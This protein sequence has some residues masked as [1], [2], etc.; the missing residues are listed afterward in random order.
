MSTAAAVIL[1]AAV[2]IYAVFG[3]ADFGAGFWD[4]IAGGA[5][6]GERPREV[7]DHSIAPVWE[8]NHVWLIFVFVRAV[9]LLPRGLR[10]D[11][12]H[13]VRPADPGRARHRA[14]RGELRVPQGGDPH[15]RPT[16][17]RRR[18]RPLLGAGAL[19]PRRRRRQRSPR[20]GSPPA[21]VAGDPWSSWVNPTSILGGVLAVC[22]TAYL[23]A[24]FL[25]CGRR[26]TLR[27]HD[28][29]LLPAPRHRRPGSRPG[30]SRWSG[31]S[32]S[33]TTPPTSSTASSP[34]PCP[35]SSS[36]P[37]AASA[38]CCSLLAAYAPAAPDS[39]PSCAVGSRRRRLGRRP[40]GLPAP[41]HPH[42]R[43][44]SRPV[45]DHHRRLRRHRASPP[46]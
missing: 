43:R 5:K 37:S 7:I 35:W 23:A 15:P 9:D 42:R 34:A 6:R 41:H 19:L 17:L 18:V 46:S 39:L 30:S 38:R 27:R 16:Q 25:V 3:G 13:P 4:L 1:F 32:C 12:A 24:F 33:T 21:A 14:P 2:T 45:R 44:G 40:V 29:R 26:P 36:R 8:A 28:G 11:H 31:S 10:L 22:V 20:A